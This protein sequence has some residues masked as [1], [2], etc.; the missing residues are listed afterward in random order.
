MLILMFKLIF[1]RFI[2]LVKRASF[3]LNLL[4]LFVSVLLL[5]FFNCIIVCDEIFK[6]FCFF[7]GCCG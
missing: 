5:S 4:I 6:D 7:I 3:A 1:T 2:A